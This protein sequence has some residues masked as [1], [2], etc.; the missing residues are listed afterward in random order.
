MGSFS[1]PR[2]LGRPFFNLP[3]V[4]HIP[5][6]NSGARVVIF[7]CTS[8]VTLCDSTMK[9]IWLASRSYFA[10]GAVSIE[11]QSLAACA[12]MTRARMA[13]I[14]L[15][16]LEYCSSL[17]IVVTAVHTFGWQTPQVACDA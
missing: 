14:F 11:R 4:T 12:A 13:T 7:F 9:S 1:T 3:L 17:R 5:P 2:I 10:L 16:S 15:K 6:S 8:V